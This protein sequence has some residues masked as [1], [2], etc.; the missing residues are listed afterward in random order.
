MLSTGILKVMIYLVT[1]FNASLTVDDSLS[2]FSLSTINDYKSCVYLA[3]VIEV[4]LSG[5]RAFMIGF[6]RVE[7]SPN[8]NQKY[9][10]LL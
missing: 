8:L 1:L 9:L 3:L 6:V 5:S 7:S 2:C 10:E 4:V